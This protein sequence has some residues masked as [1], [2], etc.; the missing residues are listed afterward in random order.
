MTAK[1]V[2]DGSGQQAFLANRMGLR[3]LNPELRKVAIWGHF[4]GA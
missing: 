2:V 1:V 4:Q 3:V